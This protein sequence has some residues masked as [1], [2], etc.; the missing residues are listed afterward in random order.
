MITEKRLKDFLHYDPAS[1][2]WAWR[3]SLGRARA[4]DLAGNKVHNGY[5]TVFIDGVRHSAH[6]LAWFYM[7][8]KLPKSEIDHINMDRA[9]NRWDNLRVATTSQNKANSGKRSNNT[10][11][12]KGIWWH[13]RAGKWAASIMVSGSKRSLGLYTTPE[14]AHA[15]YTDAAKKYFGEFARP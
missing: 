3:R 13:K 14:T 1:G 4:G 6:R 12:F 2:D 5:R 11:G 7:T 8:G 9:D 10:S 15:A